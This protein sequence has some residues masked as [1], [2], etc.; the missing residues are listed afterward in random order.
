MGKL[1]RASSFCSFG[2]MLGQVCD[3]G[4]MEQEMLL[5]WFYLAIPNHILSGST[6]A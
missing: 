1:S 5:F 6:N 4:T 3:V 2:N